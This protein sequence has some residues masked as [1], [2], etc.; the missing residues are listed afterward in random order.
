MVTMLLAQGTDPLEAAKAV[1]GLPTSAVLAL[2]CIGLIWLW[3]DTKADLVA[4][5]AE[6][7]K[8]RDERIKDLKQTIVDLGGTHGGKEAA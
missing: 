2:V 8:Q 3:K 4:A 5:N 6:A 1:G 7:D